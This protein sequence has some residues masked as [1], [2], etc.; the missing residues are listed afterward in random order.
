MRKTLDK[1]ISWTGLLLAAVLLV[2]GGLLTWAANFTNQ[3]VHDQLASQRI[4]MPAAAAIAEMAPA[5][6][7]ALQPWADGK[8][9]L[10]TGDQAKAYADHYIL[11]HMNASSGGKTYSEVSAEAGKLAKD[12]GADQAKVAEL[13]G[14]KQSLFMGN[15]LRGMLLNAYAF[16]TIGTIATIASIAAYVGGVVFLLLGLLGLRH[17]KTA[18]DVVVTREDRTPVNA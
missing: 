15:A 10:T 9:Q 13:N 11:V 14:L 5:D 2:A 12:P 1:L 17:A 3:N 4:T 6:K 7:A 8:T 16:G 18:R